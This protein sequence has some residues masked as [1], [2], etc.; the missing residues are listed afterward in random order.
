[1][2]Q[3]DS[4]IQNY[5]FIACIHRFSGAI[6]FMILN[7][8]PKWNSA[9]NRIFLSSL[10]YTK[11]LKHPDIGWKKILKPQN[12]EL[13]TLESVSV[14]HKILKHCIYTSI[15]CILFILSIYLD[16]SIRSF[17]TFM[18]VVLHIMSDYT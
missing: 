14:T 9:L 12:E 3:K 8:H 10:F 6:Y 15:S 11:D 7:I 4:I 18:Q 2:L 13:Y 17:G 16:L 1:M 5:Q